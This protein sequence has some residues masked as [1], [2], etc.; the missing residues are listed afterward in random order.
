M[1]KEK[2]TIDNIPHYLYNGVKIVLLCDSDVNNTFKPYIKETD[3]I[4]AY[5]VTEELI[6]YLNDNDIE[7]CA[8]Y[9][10]IYAYKQPD[11]E[12][13]IY[14]QVRNYENEQHLTD[15]WITEA[16]AEWDRYEREYRT[17][18]DKY[19]E[20]RSVRSYYISRINSCSNEMLPTIKSEWDN[21]IE[22]N[23]PK[24]NP[25]DVL[26]YDDSFEALLSET[27]KNI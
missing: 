16:W 26:D 17:I 11:K 18:T 5:E 8:T 25:Y 4:N 22:Q 3:E 24:N 19:Y 7:T 9:D 27:N 6:N 23:K 20:W 12:E 14:T 13:I 15:E 21:E 1:A 10:D 2:Y